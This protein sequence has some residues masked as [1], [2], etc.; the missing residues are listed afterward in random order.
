MNLKLNRTMAFLLKDSS[1]VVSTLE[2]TARSIKENVN[3]HFKD[4]HFDISYEQWEII[5]TIFD[6]PGL[7]QIE[8]AKKCGKE[9]ASV[10][11]TL[12]FLKKKNIINKVKE[13]NNKRNN[14]IF[15]TQKGN[16]LCIKARICFENISK[17]G[18]H[19]IFD[20]EVNILIKLLERIQHNY[21]AVT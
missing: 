16:E 15:L 14:R 19:N 10:S 12:K 20:R 9:P 3:N 11:R 2:N 21:S 18:L 6:N 13:E 1:Q 4:L 5:Q 7:S 17:R 8:I